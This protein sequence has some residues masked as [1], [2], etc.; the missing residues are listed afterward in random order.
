[1]CVSLILTSYFF[2]K[3]LII[4]ANEKMDEMSK[5]GWG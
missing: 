2:K 3:K 5:K 4:V 1:M